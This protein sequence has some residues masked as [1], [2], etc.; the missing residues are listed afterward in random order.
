VHDAR[1]LTAICIRIMRQI[2]VDQARHRLVRRRRQAALPVLPDRMHARTP[3]PESV[4]ALDEAL[5]RLRLLDARKADVFALRFYCA[6]T[7]DEV[8]AN[9]GIARSTASEDWRFA[10]A[11]LAAQLEGNRP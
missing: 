5:E 2:L 6:L 8:A 4:L 11:W 10:R 3:S 7:L 1:H 9:L